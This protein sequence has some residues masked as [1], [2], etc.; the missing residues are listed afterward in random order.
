M[1]SL[2]VYYDLYE[3]I[4]LIVYY[5]KWIS[6]FEK[7][8]VIL[9]CNTLMNLTCFLKNRST[10][11]KWTARG[12]LSSSP[13]RS[14]Q[15]LRQRTFFEIPQGWLK[16]IYEELI[17]NI[18]D[19]NGELDP[20]NQQAARCVQYGWH[21]CYPTAANRCRGISGWS[22]TIMWWWLPHRNMWMMSNMIL[23]LRRTFYKIDLSFHYSSIAQL[24]YDR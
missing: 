2:C 10:D 3:Q 18:F 14:E 16:T 8:N 1:L 6:K 21:G 24:F 20:G 4:R 13:F 9:A 5:V 12:C 23:S 15:N 22:I 19:K 11:K 7:F 17:L